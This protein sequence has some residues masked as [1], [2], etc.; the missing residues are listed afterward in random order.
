MQWTRLDEIELMVMMTLYMYKKKKKSY[1]TVVRSSQYEMRWSQ[2][3]CRVS[4]LAKLQGKFAQRIQRSSFFSG[5]SSWFPFSCVSG[6][7]WYGNESHEKKKK[8]LNNFI[9][10]YF[11]FFLTDRP[12]FWFSFFPS[13]VSSLSC[14]ADV[15]KNWKKKKKNVNGTNCNDLLCLIERPFLIVLICV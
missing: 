5:L 4:C 10:F 15:N 3:S 11:F 9:Y 6:D 1:W 13:N 8:K 7:M 12:S 14:L 2:L